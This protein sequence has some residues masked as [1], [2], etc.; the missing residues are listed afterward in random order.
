[1]LGRQVVQGH[2]RPTNIIV[3]SPGFNFTLRVLD[4]QEPI[5]IQAFIPEMTV[6]AFDECVIGRLSRQGEVC[7]VPVLLREP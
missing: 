2:V 1:L 3:F 7:H 4:G 6:K 5:G